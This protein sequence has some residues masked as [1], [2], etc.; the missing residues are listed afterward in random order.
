MFSLIVGIGYDD[1]LCCRALNPKPLN[2][3]LTRQ[4]T[5]SRVRSSRTGP[6]SR[7]A[8]LRIYGKARVKP[9]PGVLTAT[10]PGR[11]HVSTLSVA[12]IYYPKSTTISY[13]RPRL[14]PKASKKDPFG[15]TAR[16]LV[17]KTFSIAG[18]VRVSLAVSFRPSNRTNTPYAFWHP[19]QTALQE[20]TCRTERSLQRFSKKKTLNQP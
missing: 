3:K 13:G 8:P 16:A 15:L 19:C 1:N 11:C 18:L 6:A 12:I 5:T 4:L 2:S 14:Y 10:G 20:S 17:V 7:V 9:G